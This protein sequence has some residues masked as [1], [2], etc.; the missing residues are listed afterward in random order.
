ML[1]FKMFPCIVDEEEEEVQEQEQHQ[2]LPPPPP[3]KRPDSLD[4]VAKREVDEALS[5]AEVG[6]VLKC[7]VRLLTWNI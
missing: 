2:E 3:P 7:S 6:F 1:A 4:A 5:H